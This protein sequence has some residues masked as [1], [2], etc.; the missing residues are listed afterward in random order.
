MF[1]AT[2]IHAPALLPSKFIPND[3][4]PSVGYNPDEAAPAIVRATYG[5]DL[6]DMSTEMW[7]LTR[8][9]DHVEPALGG[10]VLGNINP[11]RA[12]TRI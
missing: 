6:A 8:G 4:I 1:A 7:F 9:L 2:S 11:N 3:C 5:E 10:G 12:G